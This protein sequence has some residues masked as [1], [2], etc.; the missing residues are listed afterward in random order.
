MPRRHPLSVAIVTRDEERNLDRC[1]TSVAWADDLIV[2]DSG[3]TDRTVDIAREHAARVETH[4]WDG[5]VAQKNRALD[6]ARR[7]WVLSLDA[8]EWLTPEGAAELRAELDSPRAD[9]Y[10]FRRRNALSGGFV[11]RAWS[12]DWQVRLFRADVGRFAGGR[13]HE[14]IRLPPG[15]TVARMAYP[16][17]H[18]AYRS[19]QQWVERMNRYSDLAALDLRDLEDLEGRSGPRGRRGVGWAR[20]ALSPPAAFLKHY[21]IK[22]GFA[23]GVRGLLVSSGAAFYVL[24]KYAKLWERSR[25]VAPELRDRDRPAQE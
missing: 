22:R 6:L 3:S 8:D 5:Y 7:D 2:L 12:P 9:A 16:L 20:L 18:E 25:P 15:A 14:S 10:A 19:I 23:D 13:V 4:P 17:Q 11:E 1:L 21:V 24:L